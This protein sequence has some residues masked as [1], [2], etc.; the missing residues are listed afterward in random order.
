MAGPW[1]IVMAAREGQ[2]WEE[3]RSAILEGKLGP[4]AVSFVSCRVLEEGL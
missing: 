1:V 3:G 4:Q 2:I